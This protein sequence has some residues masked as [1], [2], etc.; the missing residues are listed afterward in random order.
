MSFKPLNTMFGELSIFVSLYI[1]LKNVF[2]FV[3]T[4]L[5]N[6]HINKENSQND[7]PKRKSKGMKKYLESA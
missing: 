5:R 3:K 6:K 7:R 2:L 1:N 4:S